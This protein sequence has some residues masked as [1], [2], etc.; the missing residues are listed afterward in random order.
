[1]FWRKVWLLYAGYTLIQVDAEAAE[2]PSI[3]QG[4]KTQNMTVI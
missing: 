4:V 2:K 1:M 3:L